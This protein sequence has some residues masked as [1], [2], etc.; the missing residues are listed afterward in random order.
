MNIKELKTQT[1]KMMISYYNSW[2]EDD[3]MI[4][5]YKVMAFYNQVKNE[6]INRGVNLET[7]TD[8]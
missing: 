3:I 6:L 4:W 5:N 2:I 8:L 1:L 7:L